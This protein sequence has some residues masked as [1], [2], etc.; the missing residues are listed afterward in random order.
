MRAAI[1]ARYSSRGQNPL[2]V[3][4]QERICRAHAERLGLEVVGIY[5]DSAMSGFVAS[6]RPSYQDLLADAGAGRFDV[7]IAEDLDRMSRSGGDTWDLYD[8]MTALGIQINTIADGRVGTIH[9]GVRGMLSQITLE[10]LKAKVIR[11]L[12][13]VALSKRHS[14]AVPFGYRRVPRFDAA[15]EPIRGLLEVD[16]ERAATVVRIFED[17]VAGVSPEAIAGALNRDATPS[18][19]G[20]AWSGQTIRGMRK[21]KSG[22]LNQELYRG[23]LVWG[24]STHPKNRKT[25]ARRRRASPDGQAV[26]VEVP[27]LRIVSDALWEAVQA[28]QD[29]QA[30]L[31]RPERS[32]R[33]VRLL[34]GLVRCGACGSPMNINS[35]GKGRTYY[36]CTGTRA[37][38]TA[39]CQGGRTPI[40]EELE[41]RVVAAVQANLLHPDVVKSSLEHYR[42]TMADRARQASRGR[43]SRLRELAEVSRRADRLVDQV[44]EGGLSGR[45]V[46]ERLADL[47]TRRSAIEAEIA[48]DPPEVVALHPRAPERFRQ[49]IDG[50]QADLGDVAASGEAG[51]ISAAREGFRELISHVT[52]HPLPL[53]GAY[54][55]TLEANLAPLI[56]A[57][58]QQTPS[59]PSAAASQ[60]LVNA[61]KG[62]R[63]LTLARPPLTVR[64]KA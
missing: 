41:A 52:V 59:V 33:P 48:T 56:F 5:A 32:R 34:S 18:T 4:D 23:Q 24:H 11:G 17:Y 49:L 13:G 6:N 12:Q 50:L 36:H 22:L 47:E 28:R 31:G 55:I 45:A 14:G 46:A 3:D 15:G 26:Q 42:R 64:L 37:D 7:V 57:T 54:D 1:Y 40:A 27:E 53:R 20:A 51:A 9:V 60:R 58:D 62:C 44:A 38:R 19:R 61:G 8:D 63:N 35:N 39:R 10:G 29:A 30:R 21:W 43:S 25:G 16:P 2:S